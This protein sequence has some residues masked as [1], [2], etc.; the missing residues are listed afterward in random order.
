MKYVSSSVTV[1]IIIP[2]YNGG[3]FIEETINSVVKQDYPNVELIVIDDCS[4]DITVEVVRNLQSKFC[5]RFMCNEVNQGLMKTNNIAAKESLG[6][7]L[8][9]LGHDDL[10]AEN[11]I[12]KLLKGYR[13]NDVMLWCNSYVIDINGKITGT[14]LNNYIQLIKNQFSRPLLM[15][16]NYISSTGAIINRVSFDHVGGF[17][18]QYRHFGEWTL[19]IKLATIGKVRFS[20][21]SKTYYRRHSENMTSETNTQITKTVLDDYYSSAKE[22]A[23]SSFTLNIVESIFS[24]IY[25]FFQKIK[26]PL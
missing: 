6:D 23:E 17:S 26:K 2:T 18:E 16:A 7:Y 8:I 3:E 1:S 21:Q 11:H 10:L 13:E 22:L 25:K 24:Y 9:F 14:S 15:V 20:T 19:W 12:S 5:F 4:T